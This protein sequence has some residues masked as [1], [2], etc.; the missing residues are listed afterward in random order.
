VVELDALGGV[1]SRVEEGEIVGGEWWGGW[2]KEGKGGAGWGECW[3]QGGWWWWWCGASLWVGEGGWGSTGPACGTG[4][5]GK[6]SA[7]ANGEGF[8]KLVLEKP[9]RFWW[10]DASV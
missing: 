9:M 6:T 8:T 2:W 3:G 5:G 7:V 1:R 4:D 10:G